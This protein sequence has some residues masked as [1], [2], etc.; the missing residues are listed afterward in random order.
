[1]GEFVKQIACPNPDCNSSD[2]FSIY[3]DEEKNTYN[4]YCFVCTSSVPSIDSEGNVLSK[5]KGTVH[6]I[7][8][9][10]EKVNIHHIRDFPVRGVKERNLRK[11]SCDFYGMKV[12][13]AEDGN[14]IGYHYYPFTKDNT[15]VGYQ[16]RDVK[17]KNFKSI[18]H[19]KSDIDLC[20]RTLFPKGGRSIT[21]TEGFLDA[22]AFHQILVDK[23]GEK[24][25]AGMPVVSLPNGT[26][27][28]V[29]IVQGNY[30][31]LVSFDKV[32][33]MF[34]QDKPGREAAE[35]V[36]R[37]LPPKK[38]YIA[39]FALKDA[40]DMLLNDRAQ[41]LVEAFFNAESYTPAGI[42]TSGSTYE[43]LAE[44]KNKE[45]YP[46]PEC[47]SGVNAKTY[48]HRLGEI[49]LFT[50]G[51]GAGKTQFMREDI[52][53]LL[54]TT[55]FK[56]GICSLEENVEDT[57]LGIMSLDANKR[58]HLPDVEYT[59]AEYDRAWNNTMA[60][61]RIM[62]LDH[63]GSVAD[64]SL[65][66]KIEYMAATGHKFIFLD[67]IT[68]AVSDSGNYVNAAIDQ[69]MSALLKLV[70]RHDVW[71]GIVSHLRKQGTESK[72]FEEGAVPTEDDLKGSG[73][74]KQIPFDTIAFSRNKY[75][76]TE[77]ARNTVKLHVL[78]CRTTGR[79]G[80]ANKASFKEATGR[81]EYIEENVE[82][83][84]ELEQDEEF[85]TKA[86]ECII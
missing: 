70:K 29:K 33:L 38:T 83:L 75:A 66:D 34:D 42:I 36:A 11:T 31:Y 1:M 30:D 18:G 84:E 2:G 72:S 6:D 71:L 69:T 60:D 20:G 58:L 37:V 17:R 86:E 3:K 14:T 16:E 59:Q 41:A 82:E 39:T 50:A 61:D 21:I 45:S 67:H 81:L 53:H 80:Y 68:I 65:V 7:F 9:N 48:G 19:G 79:T 35:H 78:K 47:M 62:F 64:E 44:R 56:I 12:G 25:A 51:T 22:I 54:M 77:H 49:V 8:P 57:A 40:C 15:V 13:Y 43:L 26:G 46:Y 63:Q 32:I 10:E 85:I 24:K 73:S 28:A 52:Y 23:Y 55:D 5:A 74:L 76:K 27:S 4:G